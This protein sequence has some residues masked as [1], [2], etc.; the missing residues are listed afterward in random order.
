[1]IYNLFWFGITRYQKNNTAVISVQLFTLALA[2]LDAQTTNLW[3]AWYLVDVTHLAFIYSFMW[4]AALPMEAV[5]GWF[6]YP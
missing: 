2:L 1:M 5:L 6:S 4:G 3:E